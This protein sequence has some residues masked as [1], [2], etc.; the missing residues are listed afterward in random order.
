MFFAARQAQLLERRR[1]LQA[2]SR[3]LRLRITLEA[4]PLR[5]PLALADQAWA[6]IGWLAAHPQWPA[7]AAALLVVLRPRK[8]IGWALRL[9]SGWRLWRRVR[10]AVTT[11]L[12]ERLWRP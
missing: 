11:E 2:Q 10:A 3:G 7:A 4:Q 8:A 12:G 5:R 6:G 9:W 1:A